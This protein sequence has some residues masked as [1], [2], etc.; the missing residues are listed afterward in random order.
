MKLEE[1]LLKQIEYYFSDANYPKDKF[2][3][4]EAAKSAEPEADRGGAP[5][6]PSLV[7]VL[8]SC[9]P[10]GRAVLV[11]AAVAGLARTS[12]W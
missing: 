10:V 9:A 3:T 4:S 6:G 5:C 8:A 2:L 7:L 1:K 12:L 11:W